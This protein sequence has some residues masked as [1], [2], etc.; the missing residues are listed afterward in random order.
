MAMVWLFNSA[1]SPAFSSCDRW[2]FMPGARERKTAR[3]VAR[4][5][6]GYAWL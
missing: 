2:R 4:A 5:P 1:T 6:P 3:E